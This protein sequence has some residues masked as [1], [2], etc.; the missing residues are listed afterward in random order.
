[1]HLSTETQPVA[2]HSNIDNK[3]IRPGTSKQYKGGYFV[4]YPD[5]LFCL[6]VTKQQFQADRFFRQSQLSSP[7]KEKKVSQTM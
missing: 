1:M 2:S 7:T 6:Q 3:N 5:K 4:S